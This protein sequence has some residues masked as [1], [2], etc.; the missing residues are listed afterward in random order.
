MFTSKVKTKILQLLPVSLCNREGHGTLSPITH[1][2]GWRGHSTDREWRQASSSLGTMKTD[3][4]PPSKPPPTLA[5]WYEQTTFV[6]ISKK[7][8]LGDTYIFKIHF[9]IPVLFST[10]LNVK[11]ANIYVAKHSVCMY[12]CIYMQYQVRYI[13]KYIKLNLVYMPATW[14]L[15]EIYSLFL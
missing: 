11:T 14:H 2:K 9:Y 15:L 5:L 7:H 8:L 4:A 10:L 13:Y 6:V 3:P 12:I 1:A